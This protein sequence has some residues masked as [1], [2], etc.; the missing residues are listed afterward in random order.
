MNPFQPA[1]TARAPSVMAAGCRPSR[2]PLLIDLVRSRASSYRHPMPRTDSA[3][4][5]IAARPEDVFA[6]LVDEE[7]RVAWLPPEGMSGRFEEFDPRPG[8]GYRLVLTYDDEAARGKSG[9]N[10]DVVDVRFTAVEPP[11]RLVET[12][13]FVSDDPAFTGTMTVTWTVEAVTE[14][15][16]VRVTADDVPDGISKADHDAGLSSSLENL[17]EHLARRRR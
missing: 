5:T 10:T 6:A 1:T 11:A 7:A 16:L 8:G 14:G 12:S 2:R 4:R 9:A 15:T 13:E 3:S 17:A